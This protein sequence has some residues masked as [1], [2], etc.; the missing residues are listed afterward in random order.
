MDLA[1][2]WFHPAL[3]DRPKFVS[4]V[5]FSWTPSPL[6]T[7][8]HLWSAPHISYF[9]N[10]SLHSL[11]ILAIVSPGLQ[12][13]TCCFWDRA[14]FFVCETTTMWWRVYWIDWISFIVRFENDIHKR[15]INY[16][17]YIQSSRLMDTQP[18]YEML[19]ATLTWK[20][21]SF[22]QNPTLYC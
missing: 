10:V 17:E 12:H 8:R 7:W 14:S 22:L 18:G 5:T 15:H 9:M 6:T 1:Q 20:V 3:Q 16:R 11:T 21:H 13:T 2:G 4:T 19:R